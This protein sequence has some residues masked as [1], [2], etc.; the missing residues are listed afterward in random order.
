VPVGFFACLIRIDF[1]FAP[2]ILEHREKWSPA[3]PTGQGA[4]F[5]HWLLIPGCN[6]LRFHLPTARCFPP[7]IDHVLLCFSSTSRFPAPTVKRSMER[8]NHKRFNAIFSD[9]FH[10]KD[11]V[12]AIMK[13][14]RFLK[15]FTEIQGF[16]PVEEIATHTKILNYLKT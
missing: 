7:D 1:H 16:F 15:C 11:G 6:F 5:Q 14:N 4:I 3:N 2:S 9:L 13:S 8:S 10:A 12:L